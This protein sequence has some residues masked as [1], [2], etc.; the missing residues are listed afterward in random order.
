MAASEEGLVACL[1]CRQ[2]AAGWQAPWARPEGHAEAPG[3]CG[4]PACLC[5][6]VESP[7]VRA[8]GA[9]CRL[10]R[11]DVSVCGVES[12]PCVGR[13]CDPRCDSTDPR[14]GPLP[15]VPGHAVDRTAPPGS[16]CLAAFRRTRR[17]GG[18]HTVGDDPRQLLYR[19]SQAGVGG[20]KRD[21]SVIE[22]NSPPGTVC[23]ATG[24][25]EM[26]VGGA[27][28]PWPQ[29]RKPASQRGHCGVHRDGVLCA[30][31]GH[32]PG[33]G[34]DGRGPW[35]WA[36]KVPGSGREDRNCFGNIYLFIL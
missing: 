10:P 34:G 21:E 5:P 32:R 11:G 12:E 29:L 35:P 23:R 14:R 18:G 19:Y 20:N 33:V 16:R 4:P 27:R 31:P 26:A 1:S 15:R 17:G 9:S 30:R 22:D 28:C 3:P 8:P 7:C 24:R 6:G 2:P 25:G 36:W 13:G